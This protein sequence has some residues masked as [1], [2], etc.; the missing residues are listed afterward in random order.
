MYYQDWLTN[1]PNREAVYDT[2]FNGLG[3]SCLRIGNWAIEDN[4]EDN[5]SVANDAII[6]KAAK[7]Y[8][9]EQLPVLMSSWTAPAYLKANNSRNGSSAWAKGTLKKE[10]GKYV[11]EKYGKWW[12]ESLERYHQQGVYPDYISIQNEPDSDQGD[13]A[14]MVLDPSESYDVA[15]YNKAL[16]AVCAEVKKMRNAPKVIGP[17]NIGIGWNQTQNYLNNLDKNLLDGYAFHYY[18]SG[19]NEHSDRYSYPNDFIEAMRGLATNLNDKPMFMTENSALRDPKPMDAVYTAWFLANAFNINKVQYYM[20]WNLIWGDSG[21]SCISLQKWDSTYASP[22]Q[23]GFKTQPSYHGL[24]HFSKYVRPGMKLIDTWAST[25]QMTTCGF[26]SADGNSYT[27]IFINQGDNELSVTH[28]LPVDEGFDSKVVLTAPDKGIYSQL[29]G[30]YQ[31]AVT[32][33][34]H[35]IVTIAY[36]RSHVDVSPYIYRFDA[37]S[38][39]PDWTNPANWNTGCAPWPTDSIVIQSGECKLF[40]FNHTA[41]IVVLNNGTFRLTG[42][43]TVDNTIHLVGGIMK[44]YTN[45]P[46]FMLQGRGISV[47]QPSQINV[48]HGDNSFY[49]F[50]ELYGSASLDMTGVGIL[51]LRTTN[52]NYTGT[53]YVR[54]GTMIADADDA[55]GSGNIEVLRGALLKVN[56]PCVINNLRLEHDSTLLL[57]DTLMVV[58]AYFDALTIP[59][60]KYTKADFPNYIMGDGVLVVNHPYPVLTKQEGGDSVQVVKLDT[61]IVS[62]SYTWEN[63]ETVEVDWNPHQPDG[64]NVSITDWNQTVSFNGKPTE[65]GDFIYLISTVSI[66]DSIIMKTGMISVLDST[67][68]HNVKVTTVG[69]GDAVVIPS[70][71]RCGEKSVLYFNSP[72]ATTVHLTVLSATGTK[73]AEMDI[74]AVEGYNSAVLPLNRLSS[75]IYLVKVGVTDYS[76]VLKIQIK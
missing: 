49:L 6:V 29:V 67:V 19:T 4:D 12:A 42:D 10:N 46:G 54:G 39:N 72:S 35:S 24:R 41:P 50:D 64:I 60:G 53:W 17:D 65:T 5:L 52:R 36:Q 68:S 34:A 1:H 16:S 70:V 22:W 61:A 47:E 28:N 18:H 74:D 75:G 56:N 76:K 26:K 20:H 31:G 3:L 9:G 27:L 63:A 71:T 51:D 59:N 11:Y 48:G 38:N 30:S 45:N 69:V 66:E 13:Y 23:G 8:C 25:G 62:I 55:L 2:L 57:N 14:S 7:Q 44:V 33:P 32:M 37:V 58:N 15:G 40:N 21:E 43:I 73:V